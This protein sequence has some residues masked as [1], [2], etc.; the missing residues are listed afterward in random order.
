[1]PFSGFGAAIDTHSIYLS[2]GYLWQHRTKTT[3]RS[4]P[5]AGDPDIFLAI[6]YMA[7]ND[8]DVALH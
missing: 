3:G 2:T 6:A 8:N 1:M 4:L 7:N 5:Y